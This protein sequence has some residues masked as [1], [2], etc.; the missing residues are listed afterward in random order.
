MAAAAR[1]VDLDAIFAEDD[2]EPITFRFLGETWELPP[3]LPAKA[4][5]FITRCMDDGRDGDY[6]KPDELVEVVRI[7]AGDDTFEQWVDGGITEDQMGVAAVQMIRAYRR[8]GGGQGEA[9]PPADGG[10][11]PRRRS[12]STSGSSSRTST[13]STASSSKKR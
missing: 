5:L 10:P 9:Q 6:L 4:S 3:S 12:R 11:S 2:A 7:I 1:F 13:A 8:G